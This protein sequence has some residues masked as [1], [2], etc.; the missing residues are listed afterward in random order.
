MNAKA[1][2]LEKVKAAL[3]AREP[4]DPVQAAKL[5]WGLRLGALVHRLRGRGWPIL[6]ERDHN[7][8]MARYR[9]PEG[10]T[11]PTPAQGGEARP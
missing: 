9:L 5:G 3:L 11:P 2:Q 10:W 4:V 7:N 8:G 1:T 6:A